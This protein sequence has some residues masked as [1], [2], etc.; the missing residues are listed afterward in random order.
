MLTKVETLNLV[1][2]SVE[3]SSND[4]LFDIISI[5]IILIYYVLKEIRHKLLLFVCF[6]DFTR[7]V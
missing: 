4:T 6:I 7:Q 5:D 2:D 3:T 1:S